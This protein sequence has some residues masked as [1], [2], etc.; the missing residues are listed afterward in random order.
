MNVSLRKFFVDL[1]DEK[2]T[3]VGFN[4]ENILSPYGNQS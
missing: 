1:N 4:E 2:K 3:M